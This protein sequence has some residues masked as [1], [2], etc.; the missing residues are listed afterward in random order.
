MNTLTIDIGNSSVKVDAWD[1]DGVLGRYLEGDVTSDQIIK[2]A[3]ILDI[4][5]III[6]SVRKDSSE[7]IDSL[8]ARF[9]DTIVVFDNPEI[10]KYYSL[11]YEGEV[12]PDRFAAFLGAKVFFGNKPMMIVDIGTAITIDIAD[13]GEFYGGNISLGIQGRLKA[14][15]ES[16]GKLPLIN[17]LESVTGFGHDTASAIMNGVKNGVRGEIYYSARLA[18][19]KYDIKVVMVTG[20]GCREIYPVVP[21]DIRDM[22]DKYLV[23]RGLD[24]HLRTQYMHLPVGQPRL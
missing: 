17:K 20:G 21:Q 1:D 18:K 5:G 4:K 3:E 2:L 16:T 19:Q 12:G 14:L 23:G 6:S 15:S 10:R 11:N 22:E 8:R 13:K 9:R 7:F 24:Y